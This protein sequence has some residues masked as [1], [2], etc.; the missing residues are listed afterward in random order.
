[1]KH[2]RIAVIISLLLTG[3]ALVAVLPLQA[4]T[5]NDL[6]V[7][8]FKYKGEDAFGRWIFSWDTLDSESVHKFQYKNPNWLN[9]WTTMN[10]IYTQRGSGTTTVAVNA[11]AWVSGETLHFRVKLDTPEGRTPW[12]E[13]SWNF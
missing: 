3:I 1:M 2:R 6:S 13:I 10:L 12:A 8:N 7:D 11:V 4:Q 9:T 5:N